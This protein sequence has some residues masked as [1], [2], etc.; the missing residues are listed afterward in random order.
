MPGW[1]PTIEAVLR[2]LR[3]TCAADVG[4]G[5]VGSQSIIVGAVTPDHFEA[6]QY[7]VLPKDETEAVVDILRASTGLPPL[8]GEHDDEDGAVPAREVS[9]EGS[10][11]LSLA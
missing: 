6:P 1:F 5:L 8:D 7:H 2:L 4:V 11:G 9:L 10:A 3:Y